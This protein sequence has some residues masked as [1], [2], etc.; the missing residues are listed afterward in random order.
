MHSK[1]GTGAG[2]GIKARQMGI[3]T[4]AHGEG[5]N[6]HSERRHSFHKSLSIYANNGIEHQIGCQMDDTG[7]Q[8][9]HEESSV[10]IVACK[11][12]SLLIQLNPHFKHSGYRSRYVNEPPAS[13]SRMGIRFKNVVYNKPT[14]SIA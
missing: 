13:V 3:E 6:I 9:W 12:E 14:G 5:I 10:Q 8:R 1:T 7:Q 2:E 4:L 11:S